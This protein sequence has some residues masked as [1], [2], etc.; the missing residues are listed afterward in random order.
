MT[1]IKDQANS[2]YRDFKVDGVPAS[3]Q[4]D[5]AKSEIRGLFSLIDVAIAAA[6]SGIAIVST[7]ADRDAFYATEANREKLVYVNNNNG[8]ATDPANGV[9]EYVGGSTRLAQ[10]FYQSLATVV[11]PLVDE[12]EAAADRAEASAAAVPEI[13]ERMNAWQVLFYSRQ[14]PIVDTINDRVRYPAFL[15]MR[16][17]VA[18]RLVNPAD[19]GLA[20]FDV[21]IAAAG[22][23]TAYFHYIDVDAIGGSASPVKSRA[24]AEVYQE[25]L[26]HVPLG[27]SAFGRYQAVWS[28]DLVYADRPSPALLG[29][30][31]PDWIYDFG[32][33]SGPANSVYVYPGAPVW[34]FERAEAIAT[35]SNGSN[36]SS[37]PFAGFCRLTRSAASSAEALV[38]DTTTGEVSIV[39]FGQMRTKMAA[40]PDRLRILAGWWGSMLVSPLRFNIP[41]A[42]SAGGDMA[43]RL[44]ARDAAN[45]SRSASM[46]Q[47]GQITHLQKPIPGLNIQMT[48]GQSLADGQETWPR[49]S[50]AAYGGNLML[51]DAI[52]YANRDPNDRQGQFVP[53]GTLALNPLRAVVLD[54]GH[55]TVLTD[56]QVAALSPGD[57]AFGEPPS[58][59]LANGFKSLLNQHRMVMNDADRLLVAIN[60][61]YSGQNIERLL[62]GGPFGFF[63]RATDAVSK[64]YGLRAGR[65]CVVLSN[66]FMQGEF[67]YYDPDGRGGVDTTREGYRAK[68]GQYVTAKRTAFMGVTGQARPFATFMYQ[69]NGVYTRDLDANGAAGLAIGM[70]QLDVSLTRDDTFLAGPIYPVTDKNGHLDSNG[71]RWFG[72]QVAKVAYKVLVE[73]QDWEPLRPIRIEQV[74]TSVYVDF[75]VPEAPLR[76]GS[77]YVGNTATAITNRGFRVTDQSGD[78]P[79]TTVALVGQTIVRIDLGRDT[80]G[81]V[82]VWFAGEGVA[83]NGGLC[84]SD[85]FTL[86]DQYEYRAGSGMYDSANI[87][88][89]TGKPYPAVNWAVAFFYPVG[90]GL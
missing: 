65:D 36:V 26:D 40:L 57:A 75:H 6:Q 88:A 79:I 54:A 59:G 32:G 85:Q 22:S 56:G 15:L 2:V 53:F 38:L 58:I 84:D 39:G 45:L 23:G 42:S 86:P 34:D 19:Y 17:G 43:A 50:N 11:Q 66:L 20:Y 24:G 61:A 31:G 18:F 1:A 16:E 27:Y 90:F 80:S 69:T 67:N 70:A 89:L 4:N 25:S 21:P 5:P 83:G 14:L 64:A 35:V 9:Y 46:K 12:A 63:E 55:T 62:P 29:I 37:G 41:Q 60:T 72:N 76:F 52:W 3:G 48:D 47:P 28:Q 71:S 78:V 7:I 73:G 51:G 81:T 49:L 87:P 33:V 68:L 10:A 44:A 77:P 30:G 8:S 82:N 74:G 13:R